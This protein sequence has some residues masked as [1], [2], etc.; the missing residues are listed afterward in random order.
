MSLLPT[1]KPL[2][3]PTFPLV[4]GQGRPTQSFGEYLRALDTVVTAFASGLNGLPNA[5][6]DGAAAAA[7][8]PIGGLY[9]T[10]SQISVR[11]V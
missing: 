10:G 2:L 6:N 9:R 4:D 3:Q 8:V 7:G 11:V 5:A 1:K